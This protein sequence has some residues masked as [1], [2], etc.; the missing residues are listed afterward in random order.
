MSQADLFAPEVIPP[1]DQVGDPIKV[2]AHQR[3][4]REKE[5]DAPSLL[6]DWWNEVNIDLASASVREITTK[7]AASVIL[8]YEWLGTMP[9]AIKRCF[10]LF[11]DGVLAGACVFAEKPGS[12]LESNNTGQVPHDAL[13]LARGACVHWAHRHAATWF[14]S[15]VGALLSPCSIL[16]YSDPAAGEVG[17]IYQA[18]NW[19]YIGASKGGPTAVEVDGKLLTLRSFKRDRKGAVG[20]GLQAVREAF[21][22]SEIRAVGRK[23]RYVGVYGDKRY[24]KN[25]IKQLVMFP[26]P[27]REAQGKCAAQEKSR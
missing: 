14:L 1:V 2:K 12:N 15:R 11:H 23:G 3:V 18:L 17:T 22:R 25:I 21:P 16:A 5:A 26:Y 20:Q 7:N 13:Y 27:K 6:G 4:I 19:C 24:R 8:R 9:Q 10:G